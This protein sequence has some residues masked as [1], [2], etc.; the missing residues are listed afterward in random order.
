[1]FTPLSSVFI[2]DLQQV[3][4]CWVKVAFSKLYFLKKRLFVRRITI[5]SYA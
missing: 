3:I 1:M 4:I 2:A 5:F